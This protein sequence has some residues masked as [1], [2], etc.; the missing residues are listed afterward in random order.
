MK[1]II[2][3][4]GNIY[5]QHGYVAAL[6]TIVTLASLVVGVAMATGIDLGVITD[7]LN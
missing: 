6:I 2:D 4:I 3:W 1:R 7:W 5:T